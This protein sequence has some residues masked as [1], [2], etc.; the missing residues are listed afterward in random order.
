M[1]GRRRISLDLSVGDRELLLERVKELTGESEDAK[2]IEEALR[3]TESFYEL[4]EQHR[5][6][7]VANRL[8]LP[9]HR[10]NVRTAL[11]RR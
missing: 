2:A 7:I 9:H 5:E 6:E 3:A 11:E 8:D 4:V 1:G 10:I